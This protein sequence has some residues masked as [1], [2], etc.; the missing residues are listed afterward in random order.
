[1][2]RDDQPLAARGAAGG[3]R[4]WISCLS[5]QASTAPAPRRR[6]APA[7]PTDPQLNGRAALV[8]ACSA[9]PARKF[10]MHSA[11]TRTDVHES[12]ANWRIGRTGPLQVQVSPAVSRDARPGENATAT[13]LSEAR[14]R[15]RRLQQSAAAG[16]K[17][18]AQG[19]SLAVGRLP[20]A[21]PIRAA[22]LSRRR[23]N[24]SPGGSR[25][26]R[27]GCTMLVRVAGTVRP[28]FCRENTPCG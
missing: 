20:A 1:M 25:D 22:M 4:Q 7:P 10:A 2:R 15:G 26:R 13:R 6:A 18:E 5:K 17:L 16:R 9:A 8:E 14:G 12:A 3:H 21:E 23:P 11:V 19:Y 28:G 24:R 27:A